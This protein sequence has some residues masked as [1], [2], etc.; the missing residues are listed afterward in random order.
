MADAD[1]STP[2]IEVR[3][4]DK[5]FAGVKALRDV[6]LSVRRGETHALLGQNGAGKSTL[7]KILNG[8][9]PAGRY[10]GTVLVD[11]RPVEFAS[12]SDA[13]RQGV[14]YVPQEIEV[15]AQLSVAENIFAGQTSLGEGRLV[16]R[17]LLD[18]K[19][20]EILR[21]IGLDIDPAA[22]VAH[23][24][25]AQRHLVMIA[26]A[27]S[28]R[29]R[30]LMLDEPTASLSSAEVERLLEL[31]ARL[32]RGGATLLYITHRLAEVLEICDRATILKD[33]T[34]ACV[35]ERSE[36]TQD[37]LIERMSGRKAVA[38]FPPR[39]AASPAPPLLE[40]ENLTVPRR[41]GINRALHAVSF[42]V[43]PGEILGLAGLLGSGRTE[44]LSA[45][46]GLLPCTGA[47]RIAGQPVSIHTPAQ[48]RAAGIAMLTEDRKH[49]G[50]LFN[51][52][53]GQNITIGNLRRFARGGVLDR[54]LEHRAVLEQMRSLNVKARSPA[55]SV[56]HLS[57]GNQQKLLFARVLFSK[58]RILLLDEPT[59]GVDAQTRQEIYR[60]IG[61]LAGAGVALIV[62][63]SELEEVLGLAD[64]CLVVSH[65]RVVD[66]FGRGEGS[67]E[68]VLRASE[69]A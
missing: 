18:A 1:V 43:R 5:E 10:S 32:K 7:V 41:F 68:R 15:L 46:Y 37:V 3:H 42:S 30:V 48:A 66:Q 8:V 54:D 56:A 62:V 52:S 47:V 17:R 4:V 34:T 57:G 21:E 64:R 44:I 35:L 24:N 23:L 55:S 13:R 53:A 25:A 31:L 60:V 14:A 33:G 65:G 38:L 69:V 6:S 9:Y 11:G 19:A 51:L 67:D 49:N 28:T 12:P 2:A 58:P 16:K 39:Q 26:R 22:K 45:L 40:V 20:G 61:D 29:P 59:K 27:L 50:L 63:C 36:I